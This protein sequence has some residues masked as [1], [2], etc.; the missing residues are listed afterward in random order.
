[1][2]IVRYADDFKIFCRK[3]KDAFKIF[4]ATKLWLNE[5]L[6]LDINEEKSKVINLRRNY[7][8]YLGVKIKAV[9]KG[10]KLVVQSHISDKAL[11]KEKK[12]LKDQIKRIAFP[13][14]LDRRY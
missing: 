9:P 2:H 5:R 3:P 1:M 13:T 14:S 4:N 12:N 8:D 7:S 10:N 11:A 6:H